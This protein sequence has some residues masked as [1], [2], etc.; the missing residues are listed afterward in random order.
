MDGGRWLL[1]G[2]VAPQ[3][4]SAAHVLPVV[5]I[6]RQIAKGFVRKLL[7]AAAGLER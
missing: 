6:L 1:V 3:A 7:K 4:P 2:R 5:N